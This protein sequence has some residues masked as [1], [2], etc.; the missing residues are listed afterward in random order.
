MLF[1][2]RENNSLMNFQ[3]YV[4]RLEDWG[5]W[6]KN[7]NSRKRASRTRGMSFHKKYEKCLVTSETNP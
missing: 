1:E 2:D 3:N 4:C 7:A 6:K 5:N